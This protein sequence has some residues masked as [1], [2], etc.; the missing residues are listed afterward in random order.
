M[1]NLDLAWSWLDVF[2]DEKGIFKNM[3]YKQ[4]A[5]DLNQLN[6]LKA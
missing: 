5:Q 2:S 4:P 6:I 1:D 3:I